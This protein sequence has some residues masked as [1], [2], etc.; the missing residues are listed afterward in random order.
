MYDITMIG[1]GVMSVTLA[2]ILKE[3]NPSL[4]IL[5]LESLNDV[6]LESSEAWNNAG[7]GHAGL[8][9]LNY[10]P[11]VNGEID[12][13]KAL[14]VTEQFETSKQFWSYIINKYDYDPKDFIHGI[15]HMSFVHGNSINYLKKRW[16]KMNQHH[17]YNEMVYSDS[18]SMIKDWAP[19]AIE[20]R[21]K[22]DKVAATYSIGGTDVNF[23]ALTGMLTH[24]LLE[25]GVS[26]R[27]DCKVTGFKRDFNNNWQIFFE[28]PHEVRSKRIFIGA[29]GASL[30]LLEKTGI[31]EARQYGGFPIMGEWLVC[32]NESVI[33]KHG[34]KMYGEPG[35][36]APPMSV[37]HLDTRIINGKKQLLFGP[38]AGFSTKFLKIGGSR[39]DLWNSIKYYNMYS[40]IKAGLHNI[41]LTRYLI[42]ELMS[43]FGDK[44]SELKKYYPYA[45]SAHWELK[46]AGQRVQVIKKDKKKGGVL[47]FGTEPVV[48][49]DGTITALLGASPGASTSVSIMIDIIEK[50]FPEMQSIEWMKKMR[51][52]IPSYKHSLENDKELYKQVHEYTT[53]TL[54]I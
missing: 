16:D 22:S 8:C 19:L 23:G 20:G 49:K 7:T 11:M 31:P 45:T 14:H 32:D 38:R 51:I 25:D 21:D 27:V 4:K 26:I 24:S 41:P 50:S 28:S 40:M 5:I 15:P 10:T 9:E 52:M 18:N 17:F 29:G 53:N 1:A 6:G 37:P 43:D 2:K 46:T 54:K 39:M 13:T 35:L 12:I 47:Q 42:R 34:V 36:K 44:I 48:S 3:L 30:L 33:E